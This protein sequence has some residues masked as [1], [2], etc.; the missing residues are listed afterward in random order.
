MSIYSTYILSGQQVQGYRSS[1]SDLFP[2]V[3]KRLNNKDCTCCIPKDFLRIHVLREAKL[4]WGRTEALLAVPPPLFP[5][6]GRYRVNY[7]QELVSFAEYVV[8]T[9]DLV[10]SQ[11]CVQPFRPC[12]S[13]SSF[14]IRLMPVL[15]A[16]EVQ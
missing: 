5:I 14:R 8:M 11:Y 13:L 9:N 7:P 4:S 1:G 2:V 15:L 12:S 6:K 10:S 3:E 16:W